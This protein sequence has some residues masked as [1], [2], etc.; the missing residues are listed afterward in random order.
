MKNNN[1]EN[2][3]KQLNIH[4]VSCCFVCGAKIKREGNSLHVWDIEYECGC[5]I[6]GA[7]DTKT[8]GDSIE[9]NVKCPNSN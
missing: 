8:H 7:I 3:S 2:E 6:W 5:K 4:D 1:L 9:V